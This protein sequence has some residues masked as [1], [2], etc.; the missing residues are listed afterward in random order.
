[1]KIF[2]NLAGGLRT[3]FGFSQILI[4][5]AAVLW[6][7]ILTL[8]PLVRGRQSDTAKLM[9]SAGEVTLDTAPDAV[10]LNSSS[11]KAGTLSLSHLH[12]TLG[13]NFLSQ[14]PALVSALRWAIIPS[15]I[16]L[17]G[18]GWFVC[19]ALRKLCSNLHRGEV[20]SENNLRLVRRVGIIMIG[21]SLIGGLLTVWSNHAMGGYLGQR[22]A[23]TGLK[24]A[25]QFPGGLGALRFNLQP[26]FLQETDCLIIGCV[27]LVLAQ[28][29]R[30][31]LALKTE[32]ELT[33]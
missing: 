24:M 9:L 21:Y 22:V 16:A 28:A 10:E 32:S 15:M 11:A 17:L 18:Y 31:G 29:F 23:V 3:F 6:L 2:P 20:F 25:A 19:G 12:G 33:V 4:V 5:L 7:G 27:V 26:G 8:V 30:Q 13:A 1:M 14:D